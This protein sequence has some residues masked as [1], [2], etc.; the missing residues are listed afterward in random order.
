MARLSLS[1]LGPFQATLDGEP[2]TGFESNKA[3][4]LL[5]Y[6]AVESGRP[7]PRE[8]LAG[9]LWPERPNPAA[10]GSLR[11]A[12]ANLRQILRDLSPPPFLLVT[13]ETLQFNPASDHSL[14]T[15][16][17][18][19]QIASSKLQM[20]D[21]NL[22]SAI[23]LYRG[24]FLEGFSVEDSPAFEEWALLKREQLDREMLA[25]LQRLADYHGER[26][27]YES[28]QAHVRRQ[29]ALEPWREE[30]HRQLVHLLALNGQRSAALA[31]YKVCRRLLADELG[32][33]PERATVALVERIRGGLLSRGAE[34]R[35]GERTGGRSP[36][37]P[38]SSAP[39]L[40]SLSAL[41]VARERELAQLAGYLELARAGAGRVVFVTGEA[42]SGKTALLNE[43]AR[44]AIETYDDLVVAGGRCSAPAGSG[45]PYL[46]FRDILRMLAGD[47]EAQRTSGTISPEHARRLWALMPALAQALVDV[48]PDLVG[49]LVSGADLL[50]RAQA[51]TLGRADAGAA[52]LARVETLVRHK[53]LPA[54]DQ[55][56]APQPNLF[57]QVT[58]V[59]QAL[60]RQ[61]T[62]VLVL[63]DLQWVDTGSLSLLFHLGQ[64]LAPAGSRI[65]IM[66]AYR[67]ED[68]ARGR[69]ASPLLVGG[70]EGGAD[71]HP[72]V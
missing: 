61:Q 24:Q 37:P 52:W 25:A 68:V 60:A 26:G 56:A 35:G 72:L 6:L 64:R 59:L 69:R 57:E 33:E 17:F 42:G 34:E 58:N 7:Y 30:S 12:L 63:D 19:Q 49:R 23:G 1:L 70:T 62:L 3:R 47:I 38:R 10:L 27:E 13:R 53:S 31:Q 66:G 14:D 29:L 54:A 11:H 5:A 22:Q 43:F 8:T 21:C 48:G 28:A 40:P 55:P 39:S 67:P 9:L 45:D 46:P 20:A 18:Q 50:A 16:D 32:V 2:I 41:F 4:A 51:L 36:L 71:R 44:R 65:L 15:A